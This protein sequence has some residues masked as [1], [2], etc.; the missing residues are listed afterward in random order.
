MYLFKLCIESSFWL[1]FVESTFKRV[2]YFSIDTNSEKLTVNTM[3]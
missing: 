3:D 1:A 2:F